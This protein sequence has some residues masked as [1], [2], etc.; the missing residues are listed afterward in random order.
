MTVS[1]PD[2]EDVAAY[3]ALAQR[4]IGG[5]QP[6]SGPIEIREYDATWPA[7]YAGE[8]ERIRGALGHRIVRLEHV[9]STSVPGLAAK[10]VIDIAL[11]VADTTDEAAYVPDLEAAGYVL[12]IREPEWFERRLFRR[13]EPA[14]NLHTFSARCVETD[15]MLRFRDRLRVNDSDRDLY[16]RTKRALAAREWKYTQQYAD[17]KRE[18]VEQILARGASTL[19]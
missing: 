8:A 5:P 7:A 17:A 9:G 13:E 2:P 10:P 19:R 16:L 11:E 15:R 3:D 6:L 12:R 1:G 14:V 4:R 18:V